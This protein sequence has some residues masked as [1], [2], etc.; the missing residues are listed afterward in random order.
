MGAAVE[1]TRFLRLG[2]LV[3]WQGSDERGKL[4]IDTPAQASG[5]RRV[6]GNQ[7]L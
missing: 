4:I 5:L 7:F 3:G 6:V 1:F 2:H